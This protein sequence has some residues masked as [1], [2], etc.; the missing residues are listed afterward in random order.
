MGSRGFL[1]ASEILNNDAVF[2]KIVFGLLHAGWLRNNS[3]FNYCSVF[4]SENW[5]TTKVSI[6]SI[7]GVAYCENT[8]FASANFRFIR[9]Q[10]NASSNKHR[11]TSR[12][13]I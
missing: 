12:C 5:P 8:V 2:N 9:L 10:E 6:P 11:T 1:F 3:P 13:I 7:I 4:N